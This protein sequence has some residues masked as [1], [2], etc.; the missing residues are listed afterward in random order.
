MSVKFIVVFESVI[1]AFRQEPTLSTYIQN[2]TLNEYANNKVMSV[3][4]F[5]LS[6]YFSD[7][8]QIPCS[9]SVLS[10]ISRDNT[11]AFHDDSYDNTAS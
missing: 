3:F 2:F 5:Y 10:S 6:T 9:G 11:D 8:G 1:V 4:E 7:I